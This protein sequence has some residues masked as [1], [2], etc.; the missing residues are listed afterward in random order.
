MSSYY[1][2]KRTESAKVPYSFR[3]E[4][5]TKES[6]ALQATIV[7]TEATHNSISRSLS[8]KEETKLGE[9]AFQNLK[10]TLQEAYENAEGKHIYNAAFKDIC[11]HCGKPQSWAVANLKNKLFEN[12]I[13]SVLVG[14]IFSVGCYF[15]IKNEPGRFDPSW[16]MGAPMAIMGI[17]VVITLGFLVFNAAKMSSKQKMTADVMQKNLPDIDWSA[18]EGMIDMSKV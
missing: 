9:Q 3:C 12:S 10:N 18:V 15:Y 2:H 16:Q 17:A 1:K 13:I 7:G 8:Q 5:C 6:G 14:L 11:P 4:Q